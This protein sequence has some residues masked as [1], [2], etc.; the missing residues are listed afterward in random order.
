[1]WMAVDGHIR[2]HYVVEGVGWL[3]DRCCNAG[4]LVFVGMSL[5]RALPNK[6]NC[7]VAQKLRHC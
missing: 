2:I 5:I 6:P 7:G 4:F 3:L 1:M